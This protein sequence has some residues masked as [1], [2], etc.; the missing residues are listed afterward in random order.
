MTRKLP[1]PIFLFPFAIAG[2][3]EATAVEIRIDPHTILSI[4]G[5]SKLDRKRYFSISDH[6]QAFDRRVERIEDY[7]KLMRDFNP[8]FGR[9]LGPVKH[10]IPPNLREDPNRPGF[11]DLA[12]VKAH[13]SRHT[14]NDSPQLQADFGSNLNVAAHGNHNAYPEFMGRWQSQWMKEHPN[15]IGHAP[16]F[17]PENIE[18][19]AEL[20]ANVFR[21]SFNDFTRPRFFEPVNE[22]HWSYLVDPAHL[23]AWH[24]ATMKHMRKKAPDVMVGGPCNSV[25]NFYSK[26][27]HGFSGFRKFVEATKGQLDFYSFHVYD[28]HH[29][30]G[31]NFEGAILSGLPLEGVL[32]L[33][34]NHAFNAFGKTSPLVISEQGGYAKID[35]NGDKPSLLEEL[36][37]ERFP[38]SGFEWQMKARSIHE[39][40]HVN[41]TIANTLTFMEHPHTV[42]KSVPFILLES[43]AWDPKY[44]ATLFVKKDFDRDSKEWAP[45][46]LGY[47]Y[48][49]FSEIDGQRVLHSCDDPDIQLR[50]FVDGSKLHLVAH[51]LSNQ[52][53]KLE[54]KIG[55]P[56][57]IKIKRYG[58]NDDLTPFLKTETAT[59]LSGIALGAS[60]TITITASFPQTVSAKRSVNESIHYGNSTTIPVEGAA[61]ILIATPNHD[62]AESA[63]LRV[64]FNRP[65]DA[66]REIHIQLIGHELT[67]TIEDS[68]ERYTHESHGYSSTRIIR[69]DPSLLKKENKLEISFPDGL[70]GTV[71][72]AVIRI[73]QPK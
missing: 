50:A 56:D 59:S 23:S 8:S 21:Y 38:G 70:G 20:S 13:S 28:Y 33:V 69:F 36:A 29:W 52:S 18:A 51:N 54:F 58:R 61:P 34:A 55:N 16:D 53:E 39:F 1:T 63:K 46:T 5:H 48:E 40:I 22:P 3:F 72:S 9:L 44:Y 24:L 57:Q 27:Y 25:G 37:A 7:Q 10:R 11:A 35:H 60:E 67:S 41:S 15:D 71:G 32:D 43:A 45:S 17:L 42:L 6:G 14:T 2:I 19:A 12:Q 68:A 64:G 26:N 66:G 47:F 4:E 65:A 30:N 73:I 49:L 62:S 31:T